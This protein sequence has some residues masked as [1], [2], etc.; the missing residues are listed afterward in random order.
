MRD[1][2]DREDKQD[3]DQIAAKK[4]ADAHPD[5]LRE[6]ASRLMGS[7]TK[8]NEAPAEKHATQDQ[9]VPAVERLTAY[10]TDNLNGGAPTPLEAQR[11]TN[12]GNDS[13]PGDDQAKPL[14]LELRMKYGYASQEEI[15]NAKESSP[16]ET[17]VVRA[18]F[19]ESP[20]QYQCQDTC[21][22]ACQDLY[23][24]NYPEACTYTCQSV[25]LWP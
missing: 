6:E 2:P 19:S 12:Q 18:K 24:N 5:K 17:S 11:S 20:C 8:E 22:V 21:M 9:S 3:L 13:Q 25:A 16:S 7:P 23:L 10:A 15:N 14:W 1:V 4:A